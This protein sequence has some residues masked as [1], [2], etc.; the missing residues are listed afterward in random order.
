MKRVTS[1]ISFRI[2]ALALAALTVFAGCGGGAPTVETPLTTG[3]VA[4]AS[5]NGPPPATADV[6]AFKINV[7]DNLQADDKCG[8]C[9][10]PSQS[11]RF[12]RADDINLA[13]QEANTVV[14]LA[15]P[16]MSRMVVKVRGG[17]HC[18]LADNNACGD[19]LTKWITDWASVTAGG[20]GKTIQLTAPVSKDAGASKQF[21]TDPTAFSTTVWPLLKSY[22]SR[23]HTA[24]ATQSQQPYFASSD[25]ATAYLAAQT[26]INL[27]NPADSRFVLRL[28]NEFHNCWA[29]G[30][31]SVDC[32]ASANAMEAAITAFAN[33]I[34]PTM[35]DPATVLSKAMGLYDGTIAS[36]GNRYDNNAI[37]IYEF[38]TGS[39]S[40]AYDTSGVSPALDL[41][42][43]NTP[44]GGF[45]WVGGW[46]IQM[47]GGKAQGLTSTS[48]KLFDLIGS[49][50]EYSIE[51]WIAP[52][53]VAQTEA[54][55]VSYSGGVNTRN[56][57]LGQTMYNYDFFNHTTASNA[58]GAP[59]L[60]TAD[61][62]K[63]AQTALQHVV[64]TYDPVK[65]RRIYV[66]GAF[67]NAADA[68]GAALANWDNTFAFVLGN[69]V[70]GDKPWLGTIKFAAIHNR[71]L[72]LP[73]IQQNFAAGVGERY[74]LLF[75]V[76][77]ITNVP[78]SYIM[79]E[80]TQYDSYAYLFKDPKFISLDPNA[81]PGNL[82][83]KGMRIGENGAEVNVGQA[84]STLDMVITDAMY[85]NV[86]GASISSVGTVIALQRGPASDLFYLTFDQ[87]G[88]QMHA[89]TDPAVPTPAIPANAPRPSH[90]R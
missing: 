44:K 30:G 10:K 78:Q 16:G 50:N 21:P 4:A 86:A 90:D 35:I 71:A 83:L 6:Q 69:E 12:V 74:F 64:V 88:T 33:G 7:W 47:T 89:H 29:A 19:T 76:T 2:S 58:N 37:A 25:L 24:T 48:K 42:L 11:P 67:T 65:G 53:N 45:T 13:Y 70:S 73:Q 68:S 28:R 66:N 1:F 38:K 51:A 59:I 81:K 18:W 85:T 82:V 23:C 79:F 26:K 87:L 80:V 72:T 52:A 84:Y 9:H 60:A 43:T 46:G 75:N 54:H 39:G 20:G 32:A 5:Y 55:I 40:T 15:N 77:S 63:V 22:C 57:E 14:D 41:N 3:P 34:T 61:A 8:A 31:G 36:G 62:A 17:H 49:T 56:F 27:D